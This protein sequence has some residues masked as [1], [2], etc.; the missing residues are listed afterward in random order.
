MLEDNM[1]KLNLTDDYIAMVQ[2]Y[3]YN[4]PDN[5]VLAKK[6]I[7]TELFE[8]LFQ[9][10]KVIKDDDFDPNN[11]SYLIEK[12]RNHYVGTAEP[13]V[14][15]DRKLIKKYE[16]ALTSLMP[17]IEQIISDEII[18]LILNSDDSSNESNY[19]S[20]FNKEGQYLGV[21]SRI[22]LMSSKAE[23]YKTEEIYKKTIKRLCSNT[24][25]EVSDNATMSIAPSNLARIL[26]FMNP[27]IYPDVIES[28]KLNFYLKNHADYLK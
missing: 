22:F 14:I 5:D 10:V 19:V 26:H 1:K 13:D 23:S 8:T 20:L 24:Y 2:C 21:L 3:S 16:Q 4:V 18:N 11:E 15:I 25:E 9:S 6:T 17:K 12:I 28:E 27:D 7:S